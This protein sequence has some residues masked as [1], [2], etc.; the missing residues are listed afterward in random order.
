MLQNLKELIIFQNEIA[1]L[2]SEIGDA[3]NLEFLDIWGNE[4]ENLPDEIRVGAI[5]RDKDVIIPRS[6]FV[7]KKEDSVVL[8]AKKDFLH[9]VENMFRISSI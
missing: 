7:F 6:N 4:L 1:Y 8:L 9:I 2:P 3:Q 5:L